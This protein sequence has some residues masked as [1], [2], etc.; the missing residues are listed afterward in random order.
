MK[1]IKYIIGLFLSLALLFSACEEADYEFGDIETP[2]EIQI[3]AEIVGQDADHPYGDGS[4]RVNF[5]ASAKDAITYKYNYPSGGEEMAPNGA[6]SPSGANSFNILG[7]NTYRV[8]VQALGTAGVSSTQSIDVEVE[9]LYEPPAELLD[10]LTN[11]SEKTW[12][13][14]AE[15]SGHFGVGPADGDSPVWWAAAPYDKDGL[16]CYDDEM[17]F[18]IDGSFSYVTND[19]AFGQSGPMDTDFGIAWDANPGGEYENYPM[20]GFNESYVISAPDGKET[21]TFSQNGYH[22]FYVGGSHSYEILAISDTELSIKT[23]GADGLGWFGILTSGE[24]V[25][26][27]VDVEYTELLW[28]DEFDTDGQP[29]AAKWNYDIGTG[30]NGWG[31]GEV[32]YYTDRADNVTISDGTLKIT[33]KKEDYSGASYTSARMKTQGL[34]GFTYGRVDVRAKLTTGGG[35]WPAIWALGTNFETVGW[36][37]C[38]EIDI[39]EYVGNNP[40]VVQSAL[41]TTSSS[42]ATENHKSTNISN[43][44]TEFHVYSLNWSPDEIAF[45]IDDEIFYKYNPAEKD[46]ANWP[47]TADQ[48]LILN[49]AMGGSLGGAV[50]PA[51]VES[52]MEID[53]VRVYQ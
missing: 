7:I 17:T 11:G 12:R 4:G 40:G 53:Y 14:M 5:T 26:E 22:G 23:I 8:T 42:G 16:G 39:M 24:V 41:H 45:L 38:G 9:Y 52:S 44:T 19:T 31:N 47:Y 51:F 15:K 30:S 29:D 33:A 27:G 1:N 2:S 32:Q 18:N 3:T 10:M 35:T 21:I 28:S 25:E 36:P 20:P 50:D 49:V 34:F 6:A 37:A 13:V 48:F 46:D 43:E